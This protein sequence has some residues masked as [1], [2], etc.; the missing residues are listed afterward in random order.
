MCG[1]YSPILEFTSLLKSC[2]RESKLDPQTMGEAKSAADIES[3]I[4]RLGP[5]GGAGRL[6]LKAGTGTRC[7]GAANRGGA[8]G[9]VCFISYRAD[10]ETN[11]RALAI[12]VESGSATQHCA[13]DQK[14]PTTLNSVLS[15]PTLQP[16][17]FMNWKAAAH[18]ARRHA[19]SKG[20][21][22][23]YQAVLVSHW[24]RPIHA[25]PWRKSRYAVQR[26]ADGSLGEAAGE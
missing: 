16:K 7:G 13:V 11:P 20:V 2:C 9:I 12:S 10:W 25:I 3:M 24:I 4:R 14:R 18:G 6:R 22:T 26:K 15:R 8:R 19:L 5:G 23:R 21:A 1:R 17:R